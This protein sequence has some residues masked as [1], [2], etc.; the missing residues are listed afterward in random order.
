MESRKRGKKKD[1]R[2]D[3]GFSYMCTSTLFSQG[4]VQEGSQ[5]PL[6]S[7]PVGALTVSPGR[8]EKHAFRD[9]K[10]DTFPSSS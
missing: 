3:A 7:L 2:E 4:R 1:R 8:V 9:S 6:G 5:V 10:G